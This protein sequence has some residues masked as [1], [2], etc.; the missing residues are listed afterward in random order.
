MTLDSL[1]TSD[2]SNIIF[3][4]NEFGRSVSH[5]P[6]GR[7]AQAA[8]VTVIFLPDEPTLI[9]ERGQEQE[10]LGEIYIQS[11]T[12]ITDKD[13]FVIDSEHWHV[14]PGGI[15]SVEHGMRT[16]RVVKRDRSF[17]STGRGGNVL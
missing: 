11:A 10:T 5:W 9:E 14:K 4:A 1:L 8:S 2:L 17:S 16:V 3:N 12:T 6:S 13:V 15:G 7:Q